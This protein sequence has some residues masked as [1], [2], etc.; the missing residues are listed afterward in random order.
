MR[1]TEFAAV[2]YMLLGSAKLVGLEPRDYLQAAAENALTAQLPL[3]MATTDSCR[4][5]NRCAIMRSPAGSVAAAGR[6]LAP[7]MAFFLV[8]R[9]GSPPVPRCIPSRT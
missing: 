4:T 9:D 3:L 5:R 8:C 6:T 7:Y 2:L 1:G